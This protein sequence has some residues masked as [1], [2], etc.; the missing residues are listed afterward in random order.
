M[1]VFLEYI[2]FVLFLS[3]VF[4]IL[5]FALQFSTIFKKDFNMQAPASV[6][7]FKELKE[8]ICH[9]YLWKPGCVTWVLQ[10]GVSLKCCLTYTMLLSTK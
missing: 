10:I 5:Y 9:D 2:D 3:Y 8:Y 1:P 4:K 7:L 6:K